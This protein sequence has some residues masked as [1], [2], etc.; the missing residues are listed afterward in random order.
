MR[1]GIF[2]RPSV[3]G[4]RPRTRRG[5]PAQS[6]V[7]RQV[8]A[9]LVK[10]HEVSVNDSSISWRSGKCSFDKDASSRGFY[11]TKEFLPPSQLERVV[12]GIHA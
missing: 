7:G 6:A 3:I 1:D 8:G 12:A 10:L 5:R 2:T 11:G 4:N 9:Y